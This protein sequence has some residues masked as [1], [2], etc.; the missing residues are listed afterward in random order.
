[1]KKQ[2]KLMSLVT[3]LVMLTLLAVSAL[4]TAAVSAAIAPVIVSPEGI[5]KDATPTFEWTPVPTATSYKYLVYRDGSVNPIMTKTPSADFCTATLCSHTPNYTGNLKLGTYYWKVVAFKNTTKLSTSSSVKFSISAP[6][7]GFYNGFNNEKAGWDKRAGTA[8][9]YKSI[10]SYY[11][12]GTKFQWSSAYFTKSQAYTNFDYY[13]RIKRV[14]NL[15]DPNC[16]DFRMG[17]THIASNLRWHTGYAF[18]VNNAGK[19]QVVKRNADKTFTNLVPWTPIPAEADF[20]PNEFNTV[21]VVAV[22]SDM[23]FFVNG[24]KVAYVEDSDFSIGWIGFEMYKS[25]DGTGTGKQ[26]QV[27]WAK[28]ALLWD[29]ALFNALLNSR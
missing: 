10:S 3:A 18:C 19:F 8:A 14:G 15:T 22:D 23:L 24:K 12:N 11:T 29:K 2:H 9:W 1:M 25:T 27:D 13:A 7:I 26:F 17:N 20:A 21:R 6:P 28:V 4:P 5:I 16:M